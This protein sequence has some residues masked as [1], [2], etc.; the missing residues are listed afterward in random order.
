MP[1]K[2]KHNISTMQVIRYFWK[3]NMTRKLLFILCLLGVAIASIS[4]L[5]RPIY[6][7]RM[8]DVILAF[9]G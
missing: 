6:F 7:S 8:V 2:R 4:A 5:T 1:K 3:I 9:T